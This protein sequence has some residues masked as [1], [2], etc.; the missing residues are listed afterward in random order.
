MNAFRLTNLC[1]VRPAAFAFNAETAATNAF[2]HAPDAK[3]ARL[4][5]R[6][7]AAARAEFDAASAAL[8]DAG[9]RVCVVPDEA[10]PARP[11]AVFPNNWVSFHEDGTVVLY[12]MQSP[13]RRLERREALIEQ[14]KTE[15]GFVE[16]RRLDLTGEE[17]HG[18]YLEGTGSLVLDPI[19]R[20][21]YACR[22]PRTDE[23]LV[24]EWARQM[25][26][27]PLLFNAASPD[28][29]PVYHT[30]VVL[31]IGARVAGCGVEWIAPA[32]REEVAARLRAGGRDLLLFGTRALGA[33]AGNMLEIPV[34]P[35][36]RL[37]AMSS[38]ALSSLNVVQRGQIAAAG[39][40]P[41]VVDLPVIEKHGGG[42][43][44]C[45]LAEVP[46]C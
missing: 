35:Q 20:V 16:R 13:A 14:V 17:Q 32:K 43:I 24:R 42:S 19:Q 28:G 3:E 26:Y 6:I 7:A 23:S 4:P 36:R 29:R 15:L 34:A 8:R 9:A 40:E 44:R 45:M 10:E 31:W 37:L 22:S 25:D 46:Q 12:P 33:F 41:L 5:A 38:A 39:C 30:N 2:Q 18:R 21:A 27:E 1:M 11:D